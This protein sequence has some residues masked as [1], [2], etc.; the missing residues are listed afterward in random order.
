MRHDLMTLLVVATTAI[1][2]GCTSDGSAQPDKETVAVR[3]QE[4]GVAPHE[5]K[6]IFVVGVAHEDK[7]RRMFEDELVRQ[8]TAAGVDAVPS[9]TLMPEQAGATKDDVVSAVRSCAADGVVVTRLIKRE[10]STKMSASPGSYYG[11]YNTA[12]RTAYV[13]P[14]IYKS[15]TV[16]LETRLFDVG[17]EAQLWA[18]TTQAFDPRAT[19]REIAGLVRAIVKD[20]KKGQLI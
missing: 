11:H 2:T 15:E 3:W 17:S 4:A 6:K 19:E 13:P 10:R 5:F 20:M 14:V 9:Y 7:V 1:A 18:T 16:T 8:L 12:S